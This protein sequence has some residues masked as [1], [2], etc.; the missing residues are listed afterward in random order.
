[1]AA[2]QMLFIALGI[3]KLIAQH[4]ADFP[5]PGTVLNELVHRLS[6]LSKNIDGRS[7]RPIFLRNLDQAI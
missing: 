3:I 7:R 4:T 5:W 2:G 6:L 1:M